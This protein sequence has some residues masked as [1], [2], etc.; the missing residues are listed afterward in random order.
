VKIPP[1]NAGRGLTA[2]AENGSWP[3]R[4]VDKLLPSQVAKEIEAAEAHIRQGR[5]QRSLSAL[6]GASSVLAGAEVAYEHY[7]GSYGQQ[8]MYTPVVLGGAMT[9][10]GI[11]GAFSPRAARTLLRWTSAVTLLDGLVG[12]FFHVRGIQRKPG[13]WRLP[14]VNIIMGPPIFAP[15]LFGVSA[16][17]GLIASFLSPEESEPVDIRSPGTRAL[18]LVPLDKA[19][20]HPWTIELREG[21]FQ[22][23]LAAATMISTFCSGAEALYS[24][25]KNNFRYGAQ[26]TPIIITPLLMGAA[27]SAMRSPKAAGTWLPAMSALAI[28][29][30][31]V[32]FFYHVRG[33]LRRPGGMKKPLYNIIYGPPIF[34]PLLFAACG[35]IGLLASLMRRER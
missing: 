6:A 24:H 34:A 20:E 12:F 5:F 25:Y 33:V 10:A 13:G 2:A 7:R 15:L 3:D 16:Y 26:W 27:A 29:D 31:G 23:H 32:G 14:I 8:V 17:L 18:S 4:F 28:I 1:K 22:K 30:G 9:I 11:C 21:R 19:R 35:T